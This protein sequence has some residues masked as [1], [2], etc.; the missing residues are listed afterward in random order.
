MSGF[1]RID[2]RFRWLAALL[3][4]V[5]LAAPGCSSGLQ[6]S[7]AAYRGPAVGVDSTGEYH[8]I[9]A[10]LPSPGWRLTLDGKRATPDAVRMLVTLRRPNPAAVYPQVQVEQRV[11]TPIRT[12]EPVRV[13]ARRIPFAGG[14]EDDAPY[15]RVGGSQP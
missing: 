4:A 10:V 11:L 1:D 7:E 9:V 12:E 6:V 5:V 15:L 13:Y 14:D 3:A 8:E 2:R